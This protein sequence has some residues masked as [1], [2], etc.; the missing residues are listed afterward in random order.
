M[1]QGLQLPFSQEYNLLFCTKQHITLQK[2]L[3]YIS[4]I[5]FNVIL[6]KFALR[7]KHSFTIILSQTTWKYHHPELVKMSDNQ[8]IESQEDNKS[9]SLKE[10]ENIS[11]EPC[12]EQRETTNPKFK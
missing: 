1:Q 2:M 5:F 3:A 11:Q 10:N 9:E 6:I 4:N 12:I 7:P 8:N